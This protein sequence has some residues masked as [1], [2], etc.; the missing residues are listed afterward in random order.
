MSA[1]RILIEPL[2]RDGG[3]AARVTGEGTHELWI[4]SPLINIAPDD[5][6]PWAM[7]MLPYAMRKNVDLH[8]VGGVDETALENFAE[9]Q[10]TLTTW[11]PKRVRKIRVTSDSTIKSPQPAN[12]GAFFS[13]GVDSFY[14]LSKTDLD[15]ILFVGGFDI[16]ATEPER[17]ERAAEASRAAA[18]E[19]GVELL[20]ATTNM[21]QIT[22]PVVSWGFE[23]H[24][25]SLAAVAYAFRNQIG[26]MHIA[27]SYSDEDLHPWGSH[28]DLDPLWSTSGQEIL[29]TST[30]ELRVEKVAA[31]MEFPSARRHLR[32]C[33]MDTDA[34]NCGVC[35]KCVRTRINL[36]AANFDGQCEVL[37]ALDLEEVRNMRLA[38]EGARIF[39]EENLRFI[40]AAG[41]QDPAL[42]EA[43][44]YA[45]RKGARKGALIERIDRIPGARRAYRAMKSIVGR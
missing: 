26:I 45:I 36:R 42:A 4:D 39:A 9:I 8:V 27:S 22:D 14:T 40:D 34:F 28:P 21:R 16:P 15:K 2:P 7:V 13:G 38:D 10:N 25:A 41:R 35:E 5:L 3:I 24:G 11:Y 6:T 17:I 20:E 33:W 1:N 23:Q 44:D 43:L 12:V 29:H 19:F 32:V 37:P 31:I 30:R 18:E